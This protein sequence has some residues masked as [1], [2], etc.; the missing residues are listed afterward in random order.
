ML[1]LL[2][3]K[4]LRKLRCYVL[5]ASRSTTQSLQ[6]KNAPYHIPSSFPLRRGR[7]I[8]KRG[9]LQRVHLRNPRR[10]PPLHPEGKL[11]QANWWAPPSPSGLALRLPAASPPLTRES[12]FRGCKSGTGLVRRRATEGGKLYPG[13]SQRCANETEIISISCDTGKKILE[14]H[15]SQ[16]WG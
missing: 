3:A 16:A 4:R 15:I 13:T 9:Q 14:A 11:R 12:V 1:A 10:F 2:E 8:I 6:K 5:Y 7:S